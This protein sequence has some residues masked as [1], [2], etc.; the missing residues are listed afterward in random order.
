MPTP[1]RQIDS[2]RH[3]PTQRQ[4]CQVFRAAD[5][6]RQMLDHSQRRQKSLAPVRSVE[7]RGGNSALKVKQPNSRSHQIAHDG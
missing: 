4:Q 5:V 7:V 3:Q 6:S 2:R 1:F